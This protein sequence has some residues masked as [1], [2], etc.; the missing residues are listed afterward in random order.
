MR[1]SKEGL[2]LPALQVHKKAIGEEA[3]IIIPTGSIDSSTAQDFKKFC[4]DAFSPS[5]RQVLL[6]MA[7]VKY[8]SSIGLGALIGCFKESQ[9][10]NCGF[11]LYDA[12]LPVRRVLEISRLD[13]LALRPETLTP[14]NPFKD[15]VLTREAQRLSEAKPEAKKS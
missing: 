3:V 2:S 11:A 4:E 14:E 7:G 12:P 9:E 5:I 13:F 15:F 1:F 8:I 10:K 6:D